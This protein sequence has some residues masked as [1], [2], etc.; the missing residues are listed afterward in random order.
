MSDSASGDRTQ[1]RVGLEKLTVVPNNYV[2]FARTFIYYVDDEFPE[3]YFLRQNKPKSFNT[4]RTKSAEKGSRQYRDET[5]RISK[6]KVLKDTYQT[7]SNSIASRMLNFMSEDAKNKCINEDELFRL[8]LEKGRRSSLVLWRRIKEVF[9]VGSAKNENT[10]NLILL[11]EEKLSNLRQN[12][13]TLNQHTADYR[14]QIQKL[15]DLGADIDERKT[16]NKFIFS[17]NDQFS[18]SIIT[19]WTQVPTKGES[20]VPS[21]LVEA[22]R[23]TAAFVQN[24]SITINRRS[25]V[26]NQ[27]QLRSLSSD[28]SEFT[29][30]M[31]N[32]HLGSTAGSRPDNSRSK[33]GSREKGKTAE[34][35]GHSDTTGGNT[36]K[37]QNPSKPFNQR[38]DQ[39]NRKRDGSYVENRRGSENH[40]GSVGGGQFV[41]R[42]PWERDGGGGGSSGGSN[43]GGAKLHANHNPCTTCQWK[44]PN[45]RPHYGHRAQECMY[46]EEYER[47]KFQRGNNGGRNNATIVHDEEFFNFNYVV[48]KKEIAEGQFLAIDCCANWHV[49]KDDKL[50]VGGVSDAP[51]SLKMA[52]YGGDGEEKKIGYLPFFGLAIYSEKTPLN[53]VS[54]GLLTQKDSGWDCQW[55]SSTDSYIIYH[56]VFNVTYQFNRY[57]DIFISSIHPI[58]GS[59]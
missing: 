9:T 51:V 27:Q 44:L 3:G 31:A 7:L 58:V 18:D 35:R 47:S 52:G 26:A 48:T 19:S 39:N 4:K 23:V 41:N 33:R 59:I 13:K 15:K 42:K 36:T 20:M 6:Q 49:I 46:R 5:N 45:S 2:S 34:R 8:E 10:V 24:L 53:L 16:V 57:M 38:A 28:N 50:F 25:T 55:S 11:E 37:P 56:K 32:A 43:G 22:Y 12:K 54:W 40:N 17:L 29:S 14:L 30:T 21:S 1:K